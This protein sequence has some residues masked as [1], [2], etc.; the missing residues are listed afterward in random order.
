MMACLHT[1][2][3]S[4]LAA[5]N[6][7]PW[8]C[9]FAW[10]SIVLHLACS[11]VIATDIAIGRRQRMAIMNVVWPI[12]MLYGGVV[13]IWA[14]Y[15]FGRAMPHGSMHGHQQMNHSDRPM[16]QSVILGTT[17]CGAGCTLGDFLAEGGLYLV[18]ITALL[19]SKLFTS[20]I[21]DFVAAYLLGIIFQY[22]AIV[23]MRKLSFGK[24]IW[25]A[26]KADTLSLIAF[27][28]GM[29]VWMAITQKL[30]F[31]PAPEPNAA[32]YWF[33]MQIAM[34]CG[35]VTSFPMNWFLI[36]NGMKERM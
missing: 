32:V 12:T 21:F 28:I 22:F 27:Q 1:I 31:R 11:L 29:Y 20:Y 26:I 7:P 36:R 23:P 25:A 18:G 16:W 8:L 10:I 5:V 2:P 4:S 6:P 15:S 19:G 30:L 13:A 34:I 14:Y 33:M 3:I 24:G 17:H 35:F 9:A